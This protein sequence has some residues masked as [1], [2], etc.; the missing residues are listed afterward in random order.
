MINP[1]LHL[2]D[3]GRRAPRTGERPTSSHCQLPGGPAEVTGEGVP[4]IVGHLPRF[5]SF[6]T[7]VKEEILETI[8][9]NKEKRHRK[10]RGIKKKTLEEF[11]SWQ[12]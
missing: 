2:S 12:F 1:T 4:V 5:P 9:K 7:G 10:K 3:E 6:H 11:P 8:T